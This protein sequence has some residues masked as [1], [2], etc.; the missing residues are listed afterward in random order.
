MRKVLCGGLLFLAACG[1]AS[2]KAPAAQGTGRAPHV[3]ASASPAPATSAAQQA[4]HLLDSL[5]TPRQA[6]RFAP[7]DDCGKVPGAAAFRQ[8]LAEAVAHRDAV[9]IAALADPAIRLSFG[10]DNGRDRFLQK[11]QAPDGNAS[12]DNAMRELAALLPLG[13]AIDEAGGLTMPWFFA[14]DMGEID[15]YDAMLVQGVGVPLRAGPEPGA[16]VSRR[17]SWD[18]V[19]LVAGLY[20]DQPAQRVRTADGV[21]GY[22][23]TQSLRSLL[24]YR[25]LAT[26]V[27]GEWRITA[28]VAGD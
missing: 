8:R 5:V 20:P 16:P 1:S 6:G 27:G 14:Q 15:A 12:E 7:R 11:L 18:V 3:A 26:R 28:F 13:C 2:D 24:D 23:P 9:A 25:L 21:V 4:R 10:D 22:L 17:L 19:S